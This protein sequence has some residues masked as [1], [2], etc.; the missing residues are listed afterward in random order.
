MYDPVL[1]RWHCIDQ[2][3]EKYF[4][5][6][7][8]TYC[9]NNPIRLVD[10]DGRYFDERNGKK[11]G[12]IE[13]RAE[14]KASRLESK[15]NRIDK[16]G[17]DGKDVRARASELRRSASDI[18]DMRNDK[19]TEYR[20]ESLT[21]KSAIDN[22]VDGNIT[23]ETGLNPKGDKVVTM[24]TD[25]SMAMSLHEGR[26]GGDVARGTLDVSDNSTNYGVQDEI[27]AYRAQYAWDGEYIYRQYVK[28]YSG[29]ETMC[30]L[31]P[32][33]ANNIILIKITNMDQITPSMIN[34]VSSGL[35]PEQSL[36]Y[37]MQKTEQWNNN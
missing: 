11:A 14:K 25:N 27:R 9:A 5:S 22:N 30:K 8:Y 6:S 12:R 34:S 36:T 1:G 17:G 19:K 10:I 4:S 26:H 24:F 29:L 3:S 23:K 37:P 21:S 32:L 13:R 16:S 7:N 15:A 35:W 18:N 33:N 2:L 31:N 28:P 20:Y